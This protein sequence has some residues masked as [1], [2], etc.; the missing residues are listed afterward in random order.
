LKKYVYIVF[1]F[2]IPLTAKGQTFSTTTSSAI[3]GGFNYLGN[4][5]N[6]SGLA[7]LDGTTLGVVS[8]TLNITVGTTGGR[9]VPVSMQLF[10]V[11]PDGHA[12]NLYGTGSKFSVLTNQPFVFTED[13]AALSFVNVSPT[14]AQV[15]A[16]QYQPYGNFNGLN[17]GQS[18]N[19]SWRLY[20]ITAN[21]TAA[22]TIN[23]WEI[24]F[25]TSNIIPGKPNQICSKAEALINTTLTGQFVT[26]STKT[27]GILLNTN[28]PLSNNTPQ[29]ESKGS[30]VGSSSLV[31]EN[32]IWYS[33]VP[34]CIND[35]IQ[36]TSRDGFVASGIISGSC[37]QRNPNPNHINEFMNETYSYTFTTY[38]PGNT[39]YVL[40]DS[41]DGDP[42]SYDIKW[43][44]GNCTQTTITT[45]ALTKT[46]FCAGDSVYVNFT[47]TGTFTAGNVFTAQLSDAN[48]SFTSPQTIGSVT[49]TSALK[50]PSKL[51]SPLASGTGYKIRVVASA[52]ATTGTATTA[53]FQVLNL[54]PAPSTLSGKTSVC[55]G[56]KKVPYSVNTVSG[57]TR[58]HWT[59][60]AGTQIDS[61][62]ADSL[63]VKAAFGTG[64]TTVSI[65]AVNGCG[66][67]PA[68]Q[69]AITV[70]PVATPSVSLS[71]TLQGTACKGDSIRFTA[72]PTNGGTTP[73][74][75]WKINQK[76]TLGNTSFILIRSLKNKD[77]VSVKMTSNATC[78]SPTT[79]LSNKIGVSVRD[80]VRPQVV[81]TDNP[82]FCPRNPVT[83]HAATLHKG[84]S[85]QFTWYVNKTKQSTQ[86]TD[87]VLVLSTLQDKDTIRVQLQNLDQCARPSTVPAAPLVM[88][89][90]TVIVPTIS[91]SQQPVLCKGQGITLATLHSGEGSNPVYT[92]SINNQTVGTNNSASY[93]S[94][95]WNDGD[96]VQVT[97]KSSDLCASPSTVFSNKIRI[98][99]L[100][101]N[102][103]VVQL[104]PVKTG[105]CQGDTLSFQAIPSNG[106]TNPNYSWKLNNTPLNSS[107]DTYTS[108]RYQNNDTLK[109]EMLSSANCLTT[110]IADTFVVISLT[111]TLIANVKLKASTQFCKNDTAKFIASGLHGG[112]TPLFIWYVNG[113]SQSATDSLF[114]TTGLVNHD[115]VWVTMKSNAACVRPALAISQKTIVSI[116]DT[117]PTISLGGP[118]SSCQ[119][120]S[121]IFTA[122]ATAGGASPVYSWYVNG[123]IQPSTS[124]SFSG[125]QFQNGDTVKVQLTSNYACAQP[126]KVLSNPKVLRIQPTSN[127]NFSV[128]YEP[129]YCIGAPIALHSALQNAGSHPLFY[130]W[131]DGNSVAGDSSLLLNNLSAGQHSILASMKSNSPCALFDSMGTSFSIRIKDSV[132]ASL[133]IIGDTVVCEN[134]TVLFQASP[135]ISLS[136]MVYQWRQSGQNVGNGT[137]SFVTNNLVNKDQISAIL[138]TDESCIRSQTLYSDTLTMRVSSSQ[139]PT[140]TVSSVPKEICPGGNVIYIATSSAPTLND[141]YSWYVDST[142][143]PNN[144]SNSLSYSPSQTTTIRVLYSTSLTCGSFDLPA[145]APAVSFKAAVPVLTGI[146]GPSGYCAQDKDLVFL[147]DFIQNATYQWSYPM[148]AKASPDGNRLVI[149][150]GGNLTRDSIKVSASSECGQGNSVSLL[151]Q[152]KDCPHLFVPNA[153]TPSG[154]EENSLWQIKGLEQY[155]KASVQVFNRWGNLIYQS[156]GMYTPWDGTYQGK[157]VPTGTYYYVIEGINDKPISGDVTVVH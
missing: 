57:A 74:Y 60:T 9:N 157:L 38:T 39:Y 84:S 54:A 65:Q 75:Q 52:P 32:S 68:L 94:N 53:A 47:S 44:P 124:S 5:I 22:P 55:A 29:N 70:N 116:K 88:R 140:V 92:W 144:T 133:S 12:I 59:F 66:K 131:L 110:S 138:Y 114:S 71:T 35:T 156:K 151:L 24:T 56:D 4:P 11:A 123:K 85:Y 129:F 106:G 104:S 141:I 97:L 107:S 132:Q 130:W 25:G 136:N 43:F 40:L 142:L 76:D 16:S 125:K 14:S 100:P 102:K 82:S 27:Q 90:T 120:S 93:Y 128:N 17:Q 41:D 155:P 112:T 154:S 111:D 23:G 126:N 13:P 49:G 96:S 121:M 63:Q 146:S 45:T 86:S 8:V 89:A 21:T 20:G 42:F 7:T 73:S 2:L 26:G 145:T 87:S 109:I 83:L 37:S 67:G 51:P 137:S 62:S 150:L 48:G 115:S 103:P 18:A 79:A 122:M 69:Q 77:T 105:I 34:K 50:I 80:T 28:L 1:L 108:S 46:S 31:T 10:L 98:S 135:S 30:E 148:Y 95:L 134:S 152:P 6:V 81:L 127:P 33:F 15:V 153:L 117:V 118:D 3:P 36:I 99:V 139:T 119:G 19:G 143:V 113:K 147:T 78:A 58:Y 91:L 149:S 101:K 72:V 61:A 64:N